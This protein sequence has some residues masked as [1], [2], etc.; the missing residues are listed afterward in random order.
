MTSRATP[1]AYVGTELPA[2]ARATNWKRYIGDLLRPYIRGDVLEIG[3]G[4][5]ATARALTN[6]EVRTWTA[7]EP[8]QRLAAQF[9]AAPSNVTH[10]IE[11]RLI[12][13]TIDDVPSDARFDTLLYVDVLEHIADD[14][15]E[16]R[17]GVQR[18]RP[19]GQLVVLAP[20]FQSAFSAFDRAVGHYRRYSIATLA[21][22]IPQGLTP[23]AERYADSVG[24]LMSYANRFL[25]R[26]AV[27]SEGQVVFWDRVVVPMS[28]LTD[29]FLNGFWGKSVI[30]I[31][32][33]DSAPNE[34]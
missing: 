15:D 16:L 32:R 10:S 3:A 4:I 22:A 2:F 13:G 1:G 29:V 31:Y 20:A 9:S 28:R 11:A 24:L 17:R 21:S 18:L 25:L 33:R 27:P 5:G 6:S 8:D 26:R 7:V 34:R 23:V 19:G 12:V 30:G 14:R